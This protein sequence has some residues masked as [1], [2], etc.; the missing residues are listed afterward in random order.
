MGWLIVVALMIGILTIVARIH[1]KRKSLGR[2]RVADVEIYDRVE[3]DCLESGERQGEFAID[4]D[5]IT[6]LDWLE[7]G[8]HEFSKDQFRATVKWRNQGNQC[9]YKFSATAGA[10][11]NA[12]TKQSKKHIIP[13]KS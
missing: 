7:L 13:L 6:D 8:S 1:S 2:H 11:E 4:F 10:G 12:I 9:I 5:E 3:R